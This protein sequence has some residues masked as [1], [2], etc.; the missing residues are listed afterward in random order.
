MLSLDPNEGFKELVW[1]LKNNNAIVSLDSIKISNKIIRD[2]AGLS[3]ANYANDEKNPPAQLATFSPDNRFLAI[4][5]DSLIKVIDLRSHQIIAVMKAPVNS[6]NSIGF[7]PDGKMLAFKSEAE[8]LIWRTSDFADAFHFKQ[9]EKIFFTKGQSKMFVAGKTEIV[10]YDPVNNR[11]DQKIQVPSASSLSFS[12]DNKHFIAMTGS[13]GVLFDLITGNPIHQWKGVSQAWFHPN[14]PF[15]ITAKGGRYDVN[16]WCD[17]MSSS[18]L[19]KMLIREIEIWDIAA[20]QR[21]RSWKDSVAECVFLSGSGD[22]M[23]N[24]K[25]DQIISRNI[26]TGAILQQWDWHGHIPFYDITISPDSKRIVT[27]S[28][29]LNTWDIQ[30]GKVLG[31]V[32]TRQTGDWFERSLNLNTVFSNNGMYFIS[33]T[34]GSWQLISAEGKLLLRSKKNIMGLLQ[35]HLIIGRKKLLSYMRGRLNY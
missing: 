24:V 6:N 3:K 10:V 35:L 12:K 33:Q 26:T 19:T 27:N 30:S 1:D 7:S 16:S 20:F 5:T 14:Q 21:L 23:F 2:D 9:G 22:L 31:S 18:E 29:Y 28:E 34:E 13:N 11:V 4:L 17:N 32:F 25:G 15:V 8:S